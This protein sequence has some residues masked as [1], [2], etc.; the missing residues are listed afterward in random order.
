MWDKILDY[1]K[2]KK[3]YLKEVVNSKKKRVFEFKE[4]EDDVIINGFCFIDDDDKE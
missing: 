1:S 2:D 3:K 4:K